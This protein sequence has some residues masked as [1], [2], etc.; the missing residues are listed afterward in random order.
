MGKLCKKA[1]LSQHYTNHCIRVSG[2]AN[3]KRGN[4]TSK[5]VMSVSGHKSV[6]SLAIYE[7]VHEDEKL[8]MGLC[9]NFCLL[10]DPGKLPKE[11]SPP[12]HVPLL[13]IEAQKEKTSETAVVPYEP[14]T[15]DKTANFDLMQLITDTMDEVDDEELLLAANQCE[16]AILP[17]PKN[18]VS[19]MNTT[20]MM[21]TTPTATFSNCSFGTINNL[22][23][24][25]HK[26]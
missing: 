5:Q 19:N 22:N 10:Q 3:L 7:R 2:V 23:I 17:A 16:N 18:L 25:I 1:E 26:N 9:L 20:V 8:M 11:I 24:H 14:T 6:E 12:Q 13:E 15:S 4:F 21:K